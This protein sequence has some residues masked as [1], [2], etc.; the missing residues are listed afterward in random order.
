ML[1][2]NWGFTC[3]CPLCTSNSSVI[4]ASDER[5]ASLVELQQ[6]IPTDPDSL[7][8]LLGIL[9]NIIELFDEE[10]LVVD[11]PGYEEILAYAFSSFR[12]ERRAREWGERAL[13]HW[14]VLAGK[15]SF[16]AKRLRNFLANMEIHGSWGTWKEDPWEGVGKGHPWDD[17]SDHGHDHDHN[18][19]HHH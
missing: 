2:E 15:N 16:E 13:K 17:H 18:H 14:E 8:Q 4:A 7:P 12:N 9:P 5:L 11:T 6:A 1:K 19:D 10:G 3:K